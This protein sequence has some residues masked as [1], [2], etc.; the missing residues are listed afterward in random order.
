LRPDI[1]VT[2]HALPE[3]EL[4]IE[5]KRFY[6][7]R[8]RELLNAIDQA[9]SY[10]KET[11]R[12]AFCAPIRSESWSELHWRDSSVGTLALAA[13][14]RN[15]GFL[16]LSDICERMSFT[17]GGED[18]ITYAGY[19]GHRMR[20]VAR[21][22]LVLKHT[23]GSSTS[24]GFSGATEAEISKHIQTGKSL[25]QVRVA[26]AIEEGLLDLLAKGRTVLPE[27]V[28][29]RLKNRNGIDV[30]V[31]E[32]KCMLAAAN[33]QLASARANGAVPQRLN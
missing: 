29:A 21:S 27:Q 32:V 7:D 12:V 5:C 16:C 3:V 15:V 22:R 4:F 11:G 33:A 31:Q 13:G 9:E 2:L 24:R 10:A 30:S 6:D 26:I 1:G 18:L 17:L 19:R 23:R 25:E 20:G 14:R 28:V 8:I